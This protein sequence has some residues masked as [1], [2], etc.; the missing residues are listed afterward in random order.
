MKM[1]MDENYIDQEILFIVKS[2][3]RLKI[4][5]ELNDKPQSIS[6]IVKK[7]NFAYSSVSNNLNKLELKNHV[8]KENRIYEINPMTKIYFD[9]L[10][11]FKRS[12]DVIK[13]FDSLWYM[14]NIKYINNELIENL[15]ELYESRLI[16]TNPIDIYKTH[17]NI[18]RQL[19]KSKNIKGILPYIHP[20]YP[21]LIENILKNN[22]K[23][24]LIMEKNI[25]QMM[26]SQIDKNTKR[27]SVKNGN[28]K[29]HILK[30]NLEIYL[31][32]CDDSMNLGLF[33]NDG[34]YDQNRILNSDTKESI[35]WANNLFETIKQDV[36]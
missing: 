2:E 13:N 24:E 30:D 15:T 8:T 25:Y 6:E 12:I 23:I 20:E 16:E 3:I 11:E 35:H 32:I 19:I 29:I 22:G 31:L 21:L 9:Q 26:M 33:K 17:N 34:S 28:L 36:I 1:I 7:T 18:K 14:H 27:N 4:L 10:M 5:T